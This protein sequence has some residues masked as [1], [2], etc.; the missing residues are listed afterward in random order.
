[1]IK[2]NISSDTVHSGKTTLALELAKFLTERTGEAVNVVSDTRKEVLNEKYQAENSLEGLQIEIVDLN[3]DD[4][5]SFKSVVVLSSFNT[6][7]V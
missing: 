3:G 7:E 1:M 4:V 6:K 5:E 2:I